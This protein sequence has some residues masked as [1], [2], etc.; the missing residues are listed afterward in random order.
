M[1]NDQLADFDRVINAGDHALKSLKVAKAYL[2]GARAWGIADLLGGGILPGVMKHW[3]INDAKRNINDAE[4]GLQEFI[5]ALDH[6]QISGEL[7]LEIDCFLSFI[8]LFWDNFLADY[9]VQTRIKKARKSLDEIIAKVEH[10][11]S[12]LIIKSTVEHFRHSNS[13]NNKTGSIDS[14]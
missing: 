3:D 13:G 4:Q 2:D 1:Y 7:D 6:I 11:Q 10:L 8:D 14:F 12:S 5:Y 9:L